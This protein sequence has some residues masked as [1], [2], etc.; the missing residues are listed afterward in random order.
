MNSSGTDTQSGFSVPD[1]PQTVLETVEMLREGLAGETFRDEISQ[2][3][4]NIDFIVLFILKKTF[5]SL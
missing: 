5:R 2:P 4:L 1:M 3:T